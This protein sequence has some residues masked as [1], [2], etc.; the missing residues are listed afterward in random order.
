MLRQEGPV[1]L[2]GALSARIA[3]QTVV[4]GLLSGALLLTTGTL[5][6]EHWRGTPIHFL[7][8][9]GPGV[10]VPGIIPDAA[11][12]DYAS[13]WLMRRYTFTPTTVKAAHAEVAS[14]LHPALSLAFEAQ[15]RREAVLVKEAQLATQVQ[16]RE[17][18]VSRRSAGQVVVHLDAVRTVWIGGQQVREEP[19]QAEITL[20]PW[21]TGDK[22]VGLVVLK[23]SLS[24]ALSVSGT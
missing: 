3:S 17:A 1:N 4:I 15:A 9:G 2:W 12:T 19:M 13:R 23:V 8:P 21:Y 16:V 5:A 6:V 7:P 11:A 18:A 24:P 14:G 22:P 20:A 10:S